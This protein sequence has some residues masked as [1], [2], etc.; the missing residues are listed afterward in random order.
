MQEIYGICVNLSQ[1]SVVVASVGPET[2]RR[3]RPCS[4]RGG[5]A[6]EARSES[7]ERHPFPQRWHYQ[8][9]VATR[10]PETNHPQL[11]QFRPGRGIPLNDLAEIPGNSQ[12]HG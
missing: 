5:C 10:S 3:W 2:H 8:G 11:G 6:F 9:N 12:N 7:V 4:P 1:F